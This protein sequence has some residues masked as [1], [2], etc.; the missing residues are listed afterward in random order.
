MRKDARTLLP[1][2]NCVQ[3]LKKIA[4][5]AACVA[6]VTVVDHIVKLVAANW[7]SDGQ[8]YDYLGGL[9][10]VQAAYNTGAILSL[11]SQLPDG[12]RAWLLP[13]VTGLILAWVSILLLREP[14]YNP[15]VIGLSLVWAGGF[16]NLVDRV[17]YGKVFDFMNLGIGP[18]V[19]SGVF[20]VADMA[21]MAGIPIILIGWMRTRPPEPPAIPQ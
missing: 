7:L 2:G 3:N 17:A 11:G 1:G 15:A 4:A 5:C 12:L 20:N 16:S 18:V 9:F 6:A 10:R 8:R 21:I 14:E 13:A 19:R